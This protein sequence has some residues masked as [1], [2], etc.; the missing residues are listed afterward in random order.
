MFV[1]LVNIS[2]ENGRKVKREQRINARLNII[3][4]LNKR[5]LSQIVASQLVALPLKMISAAS[6]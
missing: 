3:L 5:R 6:L 1:L 2:S 4:K